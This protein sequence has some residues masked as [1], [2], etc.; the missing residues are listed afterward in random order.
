MKQLI[1]FLLSLAFFFCAFTWNTAFAYGWGYQKNNNH[2]PP[3]IGSYQE[4][5]DKYNA[6]YLDDSGEKNL[7]L[8]FDNG[9]EQGFTS[10]ILDVLKKEEVPATFFCNRTLCRK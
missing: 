9:Y 5:L 1:A 4:V 6:F 2:T 8:T 3:E 10:D 7:Y